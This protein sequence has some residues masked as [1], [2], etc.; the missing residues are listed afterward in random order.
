[1]QSSC[2]CQAWQATTRHLVVKKTPRPLIINERE[3]DWGY[4][5][6]RNRVNVLIDACEM[7][8]L[9]SKLDKH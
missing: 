5:T 2:R 6:G 7:H 1:M 8:H 4:I 3:S 9:D